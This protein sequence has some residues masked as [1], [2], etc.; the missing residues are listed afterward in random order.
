M[1]QE[2]IKTENTNTTDGKQTSYAVRPQR[3]HH[4]RLE[5]SDHDNMLAT[6]N[7]L[8]MAF[9]ALAVVGVILWNLMESHTLAAIVLIIGVALKIAEV[10]IRLFHK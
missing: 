3:A 1:T 2:D 4:R 5:Y 6:R 9:M 10:C 7:K 8:N